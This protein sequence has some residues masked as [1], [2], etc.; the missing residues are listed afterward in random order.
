MRDSFETWKR[1]GSVEN[2]EVIFQRKDG[3]TFPVLI[4][5]TNIYDNDDKLIGSN[6]IIRDIT[7]I[8]YQRKRLQENQEQMKYQYYQIKKSNDLLTITEKRYRTLYEKTPVLLRTITTE[9]ILTDCNEAYARA[10]GYTKEEAIGMSIYDHTAG[11]SVDDMKKN[12]EQ[13]HHTHE[14]S[15]KEIWM[16]RKDG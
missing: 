12:L 5:A 4:S 8:Y 13:W 6:T 10:L 3:T 11:T 15:H 1:F 14:V 16:K 7:D 9:G 2:K